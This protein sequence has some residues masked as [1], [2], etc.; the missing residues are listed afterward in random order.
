MHEA[1]S[2]TDRVVVI[3]RGRI[4]LSGDAEDED[5]RT[6]LLTALAV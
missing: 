3:E 6:R 1:L 4:V 5:D 2:V